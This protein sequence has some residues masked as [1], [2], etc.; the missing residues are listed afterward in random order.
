VKVGQRVA[1]IGNGC[2]SEYV[3]VDGAA[4]IPIPDALD[5]D[6]AA[7]FPIN[8]LELGSIGV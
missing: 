4:L 2:Y 7:A 6:T 3:V 5:I 1:F 8:Y